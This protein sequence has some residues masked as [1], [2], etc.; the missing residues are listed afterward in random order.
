MNPP[1]D[2]YKDVCKL[3]D[4]SDG[5]GWPQLRRRYYADEGLSALRFLR[6]RLDQKTRFLSN[7]L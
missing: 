6:L 1:H 2:A 7:Q 5:G 3:I 4:S